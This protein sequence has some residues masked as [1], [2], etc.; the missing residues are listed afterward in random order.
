MNSLVQ[1]P[2]NIGLDDCSSF[3]N[4]YVGQNQELINALHAFLQSESDTV[5]FL[6]GERGVGK[7]HLLQS[8]LQ[9]S[10]LHKVDNNNVC[11]LD[12]ENTSLSPS[13]LL[14]MMDD[15]VLLCLDHI[16]YVLDDELWL[17]SLFHCF[18]DL[19][20]RFGKIIVTAEASPLH[21]N[22]KL[23]DLRSRFAWGDIY[24]VQPLSDEDK[25]KALQLRASL[26]GLT[27]GDDVAKYLLS[28][29]PRNMKDLFS[30]FES[31]DVASLV[32]KRAITIPF[33]KQALLSKEWV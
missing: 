14:E 17:E 31:L 27:L 24:Q 11:H 20:Q 25:I 9:A 21:L 28:R 12:F 29:M 19:K 5:F 18:N 10:D 22:I 26:R 7:T 30:V 4:F 3:E 16:K 13:S 2:L 15:K 1:V 8:C 33:V 23:N 32:A 6:W